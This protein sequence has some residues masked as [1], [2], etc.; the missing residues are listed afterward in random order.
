MIRRW[1]LRVLVGAV[2]LYGCALVVLSSNSRS[3]IY[4]PDPAVISPGP[5]APATIKD[6]RIATRDRQTLRAWWMAP[7]PGKPVIVFFDGNGGRLHL[8]GE[9]FARVAEAGAGMLSVAY[10][11]YSGSTGTP[12]EATLHA[13]ARLAYDWVLGQVDAD[14]IVVHG[15]SLGTGVAVQLAAERPVR[16][17]IL[18][19][20]YTAVVDIAAQR[21]PFIPVSWIMKDRYLSRDWIGKVHAPLLIVHGDSDEVIPIAH[22]EKLF[23]LAN[24]PKTFARIP[25]GRHATLV[26]DGLYD[27]V[28]AFLGTTKSPRGGGHG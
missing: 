7:Q 4:H 20:P 13:D 17:L 5:E 22:G 27:H 16:A 2:A 1:A 19:A 6:I 10:R 24:E 9:R 8:Q 14:R 28:W 3:F 15:F 11:G 18:E 26:H 12:S 25:G 21:A 23:A